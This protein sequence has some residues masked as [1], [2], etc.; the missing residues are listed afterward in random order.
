MEV[1]AL[2]KEVAVF[3]VFVGWVETRGRMDERKKRGKTQQKH[4]KPNNSPFLLQLLPQLE[5]LDLYLSLPLMVQ[6]PCVRRSMDGRSERVGSGAKVPWTRRAWG[7][8][9]ARAEVREVTDD[10]AGCTAVFER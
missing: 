8:T 5:T 1:R 6:D 3:C 2:S 7:R 10:M 9:F 4:K